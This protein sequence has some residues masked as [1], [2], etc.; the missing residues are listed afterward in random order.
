MHANV[1][2]CRDFKYLLSI[3]THF[4]PN[5]KS[6]HQLCTRRH[7][8][9]RSNIP[10]HTQI[11]AHNQLPILFRPGFN[12]RNEKNMH[13]LCTASTFLK[14]VCSMAGF[15]VDVGW[16]LFFFCFS[17]LWCTLKDRQSD[18]ESSAIESERILRGAIGKGSFALVDLP[19]IG[20]TI[21][22]RKEARMKTSASYITKE[23]FTRKKCYGVFQSIQIKTT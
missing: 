3:S 9:T 1:V 14:V 20:Q 23:H 6:K 22:I 4:H 2:Q 7:T 21:T 11:L 10:K 16:L 17:L 15:K 12:S 8:L 19:G 5:E 13:K 18:S